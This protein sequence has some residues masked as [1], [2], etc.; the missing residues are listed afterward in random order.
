MD[1]DFRVGSNTARAWSE[2]GWVGLSH[3]ETNRA[4]WIER[5]AL[6]GGCPGGDF[7]VKAGQPGLASQGGPD[8]TGWTKQFDESGLGS[9]VWAV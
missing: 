8:K 9:Q 7:R 5:G 4:R 1:G 6:S 3:V 2:S